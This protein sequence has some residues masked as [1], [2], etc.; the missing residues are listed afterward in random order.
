[1]GVRQIDSALRRGLGKMKVIGTFHDVYRLASNASTNLFDP[2]NK[3]LTSFPAR[4]NKNAAQVLVEQEPIYKLQYLA[5]CDCRPLKIGDLL[6]ET[7][8]ALTDTPD[9]RMYIFADVQPL[10]PSI[11]VRVDGFGQIH[12][13]HDASI[14]TEQPELGRGTAVQAESISHEQLV[15]LANGAYSVGAAGAAQIPLGLQP[16]NRIGQNIDF[17][18]PSSTRRATYYA[19]VPR[20]PG[21]IIQPGWFLVDWNG[22][23]YRIQS[24]TE[25]K[26][27]L[28]G[29]EIICETVLIE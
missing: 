23:R 6:V 12:I 8:P 29:Y 18:T 4:I 7:G 28:Q 15:T 17:K 9:G 5:Q 2:L 1:M 22:Q 10:L 20:L 27:G 21:I 19:Y 14:M 26:V 24:A 16:Y 25:F 3:V 13:P 11:V